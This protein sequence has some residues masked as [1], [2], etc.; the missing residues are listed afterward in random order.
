MANIPGVSGYIQPGV[1]ARDR[2]V[3]RGVSIPGGLRIA[4]I[5]GFGASELTLVSSAKGEGQDGVVSPNGAAVNGRFYLIPNAPL[6]EG[7]TSIFLNGSELLGL[8]GSFSSS[9]SI[10]AGYDY[11]LDPE[12]GYLG[13][14][15][16]SIKDQNGKGYSAASTNLGTGIIEE[17]D[18][19]NLEELAV[20]DENAPNERWTL[21]C[22]SV[23]KDSSGAPIKGGAKFSV[24]GSVSGQSRD[25]AGNPILFSDTY[26]SGSV[27]QVYANENLVTQGYVMAL[28]SERGG[29]SAELLSEDAVSSGALKLLVP[30]TGTGAD[31][32]TL[33]E[34][35]ISG[36]FFSNSTANV[37]VSDAYKITSIEIDFT[38]DIIV[39]DLE[40]PLT[41]KDGNDIT[42]SGSRTVNGK[43]YN[44]LSAIPA[45][46]WS[47]RARDVIALNTPT[48]DITS[49][50]VN[51]LILIDGDAEARYRLNA[52]TQPKHDD[53]NFNILRVS[54]FESPSEGLPSLA[55]DETGLNY[56]LVETNNIIS[57]AINFGDQAFAVGDKF[58]IDVFSRSLQVN[59][60]LSVRTIIKANVND[61]ELISEPAD[62]AVKHGFA[63]LENNLSLGAALAYENGA[64]AVL[65]VQC[66]PSVPR[67]TD[68]VLLAKRDS[69]GEGGF[70]KNAGGTY[71][72]DDLYFP[73]SEVL[74][75]GYRLGK[76]DVDT[77]VKIFILRGEDEIEIFP[78]KVGFY[79][80]QFDDDTGK[81]NFIDDDT[82]Y[83]F[84]YTIARSGADIDGEGDDGVIA[85]EG[86]TYT[87]STLEYNFGSA[88]VGKKIVIRSLEKSNGDVINE[89][90]DIDAYLAGTVSDATLTISAISSDSKVTFSETV[91]AEASNIQF[92]IEDESSTERQFGL[93]LNKSIA[94]SGSLQDGDGIKVSYI[95]QNDADFF[96]TN[97]F[98]SFEKLEAF[99]TQIIV[100]LPTQTISNIFRAAV[101]H[102]ELMSSITNRKERVAYIGAQE[103]ITPDALIGNELVAVENIGVLE[104]IQGDDPEEILDGNTE[105]LANYKLNDNYTTERSVYFYPDQIVRNINGSNTLIDGF[106]LAAAAAGY[107]SA[108]TNVATP[109]TNKVLIGFNI[110]RDKVFKDLTLNQLGSV[111]ATVLQP[112]L[113]GGRILAGRTTSTSGFIEDE[114]ISIIFIRDRVKQV[115]RDA[116]QTF[117]GRVQDSA[118]NTLMLTRVTSVMS[119]L[120]SQGIIESYTNVSVERDKVDPRQIN[121]FLRFVPT[122]PINFV[123]IDIEVGI[124]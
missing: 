57:A 107:T 102:C 76:P 109:L 113:G 97:W 22:T 87:F 74:S 23:Q 52:I 69:N 24:T 54:S 100:P 66:K 62:L 85:N 81:N 105:D 50:D 5:M 96:D 42:F 40:T 39:F 79:N 59:D 95:D 36:D 92:F 48:E 35:I 110:L 117:I 121:V 49:E 30:L 115:L 11:K 3:S 20:L 106:Y 51:K 27:A 6:Q 43:V 25:S 75:G 90:A 70:A 37:Y 12:T 101:A 72:V 68:E 33:E 108:T 61:P 41:R 114:E 45:N 84:S 17:G 80:P 47:L 120:V 86:S 19:G 73:I 53:T 78:N 31:T 122:F 9:D 34:K 15:S 103:G 56:S 8:E 55:G 29:V 64:P 123:F 67:K 28:G 32:D 13:L 63:S 71:D 104:G 93:L 119:A 60:N 83:G 88:D 111:G 118:T 124:S 94:N 116:L 112:V 1:F 65:A 38:N 7:R 4:T 89:A 91:A 77:Q 16:A 99:N 14:Q 26:K 10:P 58:F 44:S 21:R 18:I 98:E 46:D 2:V 82:T